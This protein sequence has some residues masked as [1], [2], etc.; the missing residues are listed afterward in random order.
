MTAFERLDHRVFHK[1]PE[2]MSPITA[3]YT[4]VLNTAPH[5][6]VKIKPTYSRIDCN[7]WLHPPRLVERALWSV[8]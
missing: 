1:L 6:K 4:P 2:F 3:I 7:G 5:Q 8:A